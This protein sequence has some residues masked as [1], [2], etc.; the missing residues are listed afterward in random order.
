[1][2][3]P[4]FDRSKPRGSERNAASR[5]M[6]AGACVAISP[7]TSSLRTRPRGL[8]PAPPGPVARL[9]F[10]LAP[11]R[12]LHQDGELLGLAHAGLEAFPGILGIGPVGL[13]RGENLHLLA[14]PVGAAA[15]G[16]I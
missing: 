1:M 8:R 3:W 4:H 10:A 14:H 12:D 16:E 11:S 13:G 2:S 9:P 7:R 6:V 15:F 5:S